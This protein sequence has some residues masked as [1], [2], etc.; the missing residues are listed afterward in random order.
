MELLGQLFGVTS[1]TISRASQEVRPEVFA[2]GG[3]QFLDTA[4]SRSDHPRW[5]SALPDAPPQEPSS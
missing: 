5:E 4:T 1:M 3:A 2:E